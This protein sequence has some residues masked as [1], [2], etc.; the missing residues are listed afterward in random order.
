MPDDT[1]VSEFL[2]KV[3]LDQ[4]GLKRVQDGLAR[5]RSAIKDTVAEVKKMDLAGR[6]GSQGML[7]LVEATQKAQSR[8]G[9]LAGS[10]RTDAS[11][12]QK[13]QAEARKAADAIEDTST[14]ASKFNAGNTLSKFSQLASPFSPQLAGALN[15]GGDAVEAVPKLGELKEAIAGVGVAGVVAAAGVGAAAAAILYANQHVADYTSGLREVTERE[16]EFYELR[17]AGTT[18]SI[19]AAIE[20]AK[21]EQQVAQARVDDL[22][23]VAAGYDELHRR[24]GLLSGFADG[25]IEVFGAFGATNFKDIRDARLQYDEAQAALGKANKQVELYTGLLDDQSTATND[26][27]AREKDLLDRRREA[28]TQ[29]AQLNEQERDLRARADETNLQ[30]SQDRNLR[31]KRAKEDFDAQQE[32]AERGHQG[33]L[34]E[35]TKN[36]QK[37]IQ[38][39]NA[40]IAKLGESLNKVAADYF[41]KRGDVERDYMQSELKALEKFRRDEA[42]S[43][44][45]YGKNRKRALEDLNQSLLDAEADNNVVAF[46]QA[47]REGE[48]NLQRMAE[49][50]S[51]EEAERQ[52]QFNEERELARQQFQERL[53]QLQEEAEQRRADIQEQIAERQQAKQELL[54]DIAEQLAAEKQRY[55]EQSDANAAS[56]KQR[57]DRQREDDQITDRRRADALAKSLQEIEQK[58]AAEVKAAEGVKIA[59]T[60]AGNTI[61]GIAASIRSGLSSGSKTTSSTSGGGST[62]G[63]TKKPTAFATGGFATRP[64]S[65]LLGERPGWGDAVIPYR[66]SEGF[67]R[68]MARMG[69]GGMQVVINQG[70]VIVSDYA[71][72]AEVQQIISAENV[73][74]GAAVVKGIQLSRSGAQA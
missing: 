5:T 35:I 12:F 40:Q 20:E 73:K 60:A 66:Q 43:D 17:V 28:A 10:I 58:K 25:V 49:D 2:Y 48:K 3:D 71:S 38:D 39:A 31:D 4:A 59:W 53:D 9:S 54:K 47:Q 15:F 41:K 72:K 50:H 44:A 70:T 13:L 36:G 24:A 19:Q 37:R 18:K 65:A 21:F 64:T 7:N 23:S 46:L 74:L 1:S 57:A 67:E 68:A 26:A 22:Q 56:F 61:A 45:E 16:R 27:A 51:D 14:K 8:L 34:S 52:R 6:S 55:K 69:L 32:A 63:G 42:K 29:I 33:R 30:T 11:E 62:G